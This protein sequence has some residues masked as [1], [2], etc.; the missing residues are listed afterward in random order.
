VKSKLV[1]PEHD[2]PQFIRN[3]TGGPWPLIQYFAESAECQAQ[4]RLERAILRQLGY[5]GDIKI[6]LVYA[7]PGAPTTAKEDEWDAVEHGGLNDNNAGRVQGG[8]RQFAFLGDLP[9]VVGK[10]YQQTDKDA[11]GL[12]H[13]E[14]CVRLAAGGVTKYYGGGG[15]VYATID[16]VINGRRSSGG[17][18]VIEPCFDSLIWI[19][20]DDDTDQSP[21]KIVEVVKRYAAGVPP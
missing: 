6:M 21:F 3:L 17:G 19:E 5:A 13:F 4:V 11:P 12:N 15:G 16:E 2:H 7:L 20:A 1:P 14:A 10:K 18:W 8:F 9:P